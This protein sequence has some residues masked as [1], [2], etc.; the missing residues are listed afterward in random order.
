LPGTRGGRRGNSVRLRA[1]LHRCRR[2]RSGQLRLANAIRGV[3]NV[4][5]GIGLDT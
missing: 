4:C 2:G 1:G 3:A 5:R